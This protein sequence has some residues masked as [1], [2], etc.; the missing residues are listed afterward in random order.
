MK[1]VLIA[2]IAQRYAVPVLTV[3]K[4]FQYLPVVCYGGF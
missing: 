2:T 3:D 4:H 1:P